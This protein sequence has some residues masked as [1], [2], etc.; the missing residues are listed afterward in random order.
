LLPTGCSIAKAKPSGDFGRSPGNFR[1][2]VAAGSSRFDGLIRIQVWNA[3]TQTLEVGE[4]KQNAE[5]Q[6]GTHRPTKRPSSFEH[7]S[8][9][10]TLTC[11]VKKQSKPAK[12]GA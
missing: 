7:G 10:K 1:R 9:A 2:L 5:Q 6:S 12:V 11:A 4:H 8:L 3:E